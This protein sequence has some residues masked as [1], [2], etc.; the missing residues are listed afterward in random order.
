MKNMTITIMSILFFS[1]VAYATNPPAEAVKAFKI[2]FPEAT[3]VKWDKEN[4]HNYEASF[5]LNSFNYSANYSD[6]GE[7]LETESPFTYEKLSPEIKNSFEVAHKNQK[8]KGVSKIE[9]A[10]GVV[11]YEIEVKSG[12]KTIEYFYTADGV[13]TKE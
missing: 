6:E 8:A 10:K 1:Y 4:A 3:H 12:I 5:K 7:W 13:E 2:K 11:K 9:Q